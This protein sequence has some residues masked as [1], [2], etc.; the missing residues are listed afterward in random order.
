MKMEKT[1]EFLRSVYPGRTIAVNSSYT[2]YHNIQAERALWWE[3]RITV[4][5]FSEQTHNCIQ[6]F[7]ATMA[8]AVEKATDYAQQ[9]A[10]AVE[11]DAKLEGVQ[12]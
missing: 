5:G 11:E 10:D 8:E 2:F 6:F 3:Y 4:H 9:L 1:M 7:G 12:S